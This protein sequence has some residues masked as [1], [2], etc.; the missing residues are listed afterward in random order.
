MTPTCY[1]SPHGHLAFLPTAQSKMRDVHLC[2]CLIECIKSGFSRY[3]CV[4]NVGFIGYLV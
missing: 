2:I 1:N 4:Y 3:L